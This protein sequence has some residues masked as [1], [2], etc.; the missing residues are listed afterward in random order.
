M[1]E[2]LV[3]DLPATTEPALEDRRFIRRDTTL[4]PTRHSETDLLATELVGNVSYCR[5]QRQR[6][7]IRPGRTPR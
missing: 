7:W 1:A 3:L 5:G 2:S 6:T 4:D